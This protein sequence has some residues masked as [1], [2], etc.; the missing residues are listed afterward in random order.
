VGGGHPHDRLLLRAQHAPRLH[1][2]RRGGRAPDARPRLPHA[3]PRNGPHPARLVLPPERLTMCA[4]CHT[5]PTAH[6][7]PA[8]DALRTLAGLGYVRRRAKALN[9]S[10]T[11][12]ALVA[13]WRGVTVIKRAGEEPIRAA[14]AREFARERDQVLAALDRISQ[15][16]VFPLD[17]WARAMAAEIGPGALAA[18]RAGFEAGAARVGMVDV[19]PFRPDDPRVRLPL[20][21]ILSK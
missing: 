12:E 3:P 7:A 18:I 5:A 17:E 15:S 19:L 9:R 11:E 16:L 4:A 8:P 21:A 14:A 6:A 2:R 20:N 10:L 13:E 1:R